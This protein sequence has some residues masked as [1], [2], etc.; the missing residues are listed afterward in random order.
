MSLIRPYSSVLEKGTGQVEGNISAFA[1]IGQMDRLKSEAKWRTTD[2]NT[3]VPTPAFPREASFASPDEGRKCTGI[4]C[5]FPGLVVMSCPQGVNSRRWLKTMQQLHVPV[6][7]TL[8]SFLVLGLLLRLGVSKNQWTGPPVSHRENPIMSP[9]NKTPGFHTTTQAADQSSQD[10]KWPRIILDF[11]EEMV[12]PEQKGSKHGEADGLEQQRSLPSNWLTATQPED[13]AERVSSSLG[14]C[15]KATLCH[16]L[17]LESTNSWR[18]RAPALQ[19]CEAP[20]L[21]PHRSTREKVVTG[22]LATGN[23]TQTPDP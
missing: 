19:S 12:I 16:L 23:Q 4:P 6:E 8:A 1:Q 10:L 14:N 20:N 7:P 2:N 22:Q 17:A 9:T 3:P 18:Q 21:G 15:G 13:V 5:T 11:N